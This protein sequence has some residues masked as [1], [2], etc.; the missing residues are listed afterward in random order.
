MTSLLFLTSCSNEDRTN[1]ISQELILPKT[2]T[3][4]TQTDEDYRMCTLTYNGNKILDITNRL[5]RINFLYDGDKIFKQIKYD[6]IN[7]KEIKHSEILYSYEND[8]LKT[9]TK[10]I[11]G[12]DIVKYVYLYNEDDT[13]RKEIYDVDSQTG[14]ELKSNTKELLLFSNG[15]LIK[16][17]LNIENGLF[18][19]TSNS[20]YE[21]DDNHNV[22]KNILGF[23]LLLDQAYIDSQINISCLNNI[24]KQV[25]AIKSQSEIVSEPY[26]NI[27]KYDYNYNGYPMKK[28]VY[29]MS[30][31]INEEIVYKY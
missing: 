20:I 10:S 28:T 6:I 5:W 13:I 27:V 23:D 22:F 14:V 19:Y 8:K 25:T 11:N 31:M 21:Y 26:F 7:N 24:K 18:S 30:G 17:N 2:I 15:N 3:Y 9:V 1:T 4:L 16:K 12:H 29:D